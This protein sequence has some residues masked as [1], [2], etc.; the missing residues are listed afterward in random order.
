MAKTEN[1]MYNYCPRPISPGPS[2]TA[3]KSGKCDLPLS[4][5]RRNEISERWAS[6]CWNPNCISPNVMWGEGTRLRGTRR[7]H[8]ACHKWNLLTVEVIIACWIWWSGRIPILCWA[9]GRKVEGCFWLEWEGDTRAIA[10]KP[11]SCLSSDLSF[12]FFHHEKLILHTL[13]PFWAS[14][15]GLTAMRM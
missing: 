4:L 14:W 1:P 2:V 11:C 8:G 10:Y 15:G 7:G 6:F 5:G 9:S 3:R 13:T 12:V